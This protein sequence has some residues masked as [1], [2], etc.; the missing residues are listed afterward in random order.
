MTNFCF[1]PKLPETF[2]QSRR[3]R[4]GKTEPCS[5]YCSLTHPKL[6][7]YWYRYISKL[8][9][10]AFQLLL[11]ACKQLN[12]QRSHK[13]LISFP[14]ANSVACLLPLSLSLYLTLSLLHFDTLCGNFG[15]LQVRHFT[16]LW[17]VTVH[18]LPYLQCVACTQEGSQ[19]F[20][21]YV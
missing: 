2:K 12:W 14:F 8:L 4:I 1:R 15:P 11:R 10:L 6:P 18:Y 16:W 21:Q 13:Y 7:G 5:R 19:L 20:T 9:A 3:E 17:G